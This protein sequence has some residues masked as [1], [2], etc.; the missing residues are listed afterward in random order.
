LGFGLRLAGCG[1]GVFY[2][3]K[4]TSGPFI[5]LPLT[6]RYVAIVM[7]GGSGSLVGSL[8]GGLILGIAETLAGFFLG[9]S[10]VPCVAFFALVLVL[11]LK[12]RGYSNMFKKWLTPSGGVWILVLV[13]LLFLPRVLDPYWVVFLLLLFM[14]IG[15]G[16]ASTS[17]RDT[18]L[19]QFRSLCL[20]WDQR[21]WF[22]ILYSKGVPFVFCLATGVLVTLIFAS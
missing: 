9:S 2:S 16:Q 20:F 10:L 1:A 7:L 3:S 14:Y 4:F 17:R 21:L 19:C 13:G 8:V 15:I 11:L 12:P 6:I 22:S 18:W 5:G